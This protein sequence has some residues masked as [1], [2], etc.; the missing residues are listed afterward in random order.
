MW[1]HIEVAHEL[2]I[3]FKALCVITKAGRGAAW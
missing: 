2:K 1:Y 3:N